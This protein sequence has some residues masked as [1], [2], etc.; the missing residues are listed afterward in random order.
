M[1]T[2][3][4]STCWL[5]WSGGLRSRYTRGVNEDLP[6]VEPVPDPGLSP[7][8]RLTLGELHGFLNGLEPGWYKTRDLYPRYAAWAEREGKPQV[9][10]KGLGESI[11]RELNPNRSYVSGHVS[12]W[13][14]LE[15]MTRP[16]TELEEYAEGRAWFV[17][18]TGR[19]PKPG[20]PEEF[21]LN[22]SLKS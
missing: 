4:E 13:H 18:V 14:I 20:S 6:A 19:D 22:Q 16:K 11:R 2:S 12:V 21:A 10:V 3:A 1:S 15:T 17:D 9:T 7:P 8:N 5:R